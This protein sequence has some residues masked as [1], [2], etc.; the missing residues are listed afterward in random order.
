MARRDGEKK[1]RMRGHP[2]WS[3]ELLPLWLYEEGMK[4]RILDYLQLSL[5]GT[6]LTALGTLNIFEPKLETLI[7]GGACVLCG[8]I[9]A[10]SNKEAL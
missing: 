3:L 4:K 5:Q 2:D 8:L 1:L 9:I 10:I 6:G 7:F